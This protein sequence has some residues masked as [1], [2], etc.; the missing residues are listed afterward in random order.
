LGAWML[1]KQRNACVFE[2]DSPSVLLH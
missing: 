1:S 2:V